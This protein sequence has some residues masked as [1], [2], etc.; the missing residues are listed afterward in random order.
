MI[1]SAF[2]LSIDEGQYWNKDFICAQVFSDSLLIFIDEERKVLRNSHGQKRREGE[3]ISFNSDHY[4]VSIL[5]DKIVEEKRMFK[6]KI[7]VFNVQKAENIFSSKFYGKKI[8]EQVKRRSHKY[9]SS[10]GRPVNERSF[11]ALAGQG[12][13]VII[14]FLYI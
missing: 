6:G 11:G 3:S 8:K 13:V 9:P 10:K 1:S 12:L 7:E 4:K 2:V 5:V 14:K